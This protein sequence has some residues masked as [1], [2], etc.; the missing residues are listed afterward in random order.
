MTRRWRRLGL[1]NRNWI[2]ERLTCTHG[3]GLTLG[4][5]NQVTPEGWPTLF[6]KDLPPQ[7][8]IN[9]RVEQPAIYFGQLSN[10]HVF[11]R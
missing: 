11:L 2:N 9:L 6:I 7:S 5:V 8:S 1:P 3:Y 4:P 10:H